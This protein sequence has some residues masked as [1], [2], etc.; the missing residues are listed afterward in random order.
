[1]RGVGLRDSNGFYDWA[2]VDAAAYRREALS[3]L[4]GMLRYSGHLRAPG[5]ALAADTKGSK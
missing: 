3:R 4:V 5:S 1:L 2:S